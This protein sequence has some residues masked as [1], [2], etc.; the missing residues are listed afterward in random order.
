M[1]S[2]GRILL[3][4]TLAVANMGFGQDFSLYQHKTF[5]GPEGELPYRILLPENYTKEAK[6]PLVLFL[7]GAGE[8]G[9]DNQKQLTHGAAMFLRDS[10]R[11][12]YPAIVVFP[13]CPQNSSWAKLEVKGDWQDGEFIFFKKAAPTKEMLLVEGLI[14]TLKATYPIHKKQMY[15]GGLSMGGFGAFELVNRNP[16]MFV[17]AF[18]ICGGANPAIAA[19][20]KRTDW[21][22]FHGGADRVVPAKYSTQMV[23]ALKNKKEKVRYSLYPGVGHNSW[24]HAFKEPE[25]FS[26]LFSKSK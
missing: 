5:V 21:W 15:L 26:W 2:L 23:T 11:K 22:V 17:R 25:L 10:I 14:K 24:D 20:L 13:Q 6:Y 19:R 1:G 9:K 16:K 4:L 12:K 7:H 3:F 8:R 18:P